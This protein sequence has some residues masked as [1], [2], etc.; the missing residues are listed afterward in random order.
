MQDGEQ[1][2]LLCIRLKNIYEIFKVSALDNTQN[3]NGIF[4]PKVVKKFYRFFV[5]I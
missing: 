5:N 1:Q 2:K 4:D 3:Q